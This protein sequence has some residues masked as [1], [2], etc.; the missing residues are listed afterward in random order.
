M[1]MY[2]LAVTIIALATV[3]AWMVVEKISVKREMKQLT[4]DYLK[5]N[6]SFINPNV[7]VYNEV[8]EDLAKE[9]KY[10][11]WVEDAKKDNN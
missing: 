5:K 1:K 8:I 4:D 10:L 3:I 9:E 2:L 11:N 6:D 7:D